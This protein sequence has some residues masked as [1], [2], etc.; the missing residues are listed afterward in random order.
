MVLSDG[1]G[2]HD[3]GEHASAAAIE[4]FVQSYATE[5]GAEATRLELALLAANQRIARDADANPALRG[6]GCTLVGASLTSVGLHLISVGDSAAYLFRNG[7]LKRLNADHSMGPVLQQ[8]VVLGTLKQ[9]EVDCHPHRQ[10][11]R[12]AVMGRDLSLVDLRRE[13]LE[14]LPGDKVLLASDGILTLPEVRLVELLNRHTDQTAAALSGILVEAVTSAGNPHQDNVTVMVAAL[15]AKQTEPVK[16]APSWIRLLPGRGRMPAATEHVLQP[17]ILAI[18]GAGFLMAALVVGVITTW[19]Q[20][21]PMP[22]I[23]PSSIATER[24]GAAPQTAGPPDNQR[25]PVEMR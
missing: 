22:G 9:E 25:D 6:M 5:T 12:S 8:A 10:A 20:W 24:S 14:L 13:P 18:L 7:E 1:M 21:R 3:G 15:P 19:H 23:T 4:A 11:L 2:G 17:R 16:K